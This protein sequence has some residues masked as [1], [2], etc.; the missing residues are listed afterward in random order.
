MTE[1]AWLP[2]AVNL[3]EYCGW[4]PQP[5]AC[6]LADGWREPIGVLRLAVNRVIIAVR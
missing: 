6:R 4:K 2:A 1:G 3:D 5:R